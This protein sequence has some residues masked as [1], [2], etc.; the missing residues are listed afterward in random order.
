MQVDRG[1]VVIVDFPYGEGHGSKV[2]PAV[3][4]QC[5]ADNRRLDTIIVAMITKQTALVGREP[6]HVFIDISTEAGKASGLWLPSVV[7]CS[8]VAT[9]KSNRVARR[10][11]R[12]A[13]SLMEQLSGCLREGL[14]L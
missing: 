8:Q 9:I 6:R 11:G 14:G 3:V 12:L 4:V 10:L 2:R 7:N 5:D 13:D 1:D